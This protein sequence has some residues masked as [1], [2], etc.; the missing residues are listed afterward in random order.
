MTLVGLL[1]A[2]TG[3]AAVKQLSMS[4]TQARYAPAV[5][6]RPLWPPRTVDGEYQVTGTNPPGTNPSPDLLS[7]NP[8]GT[9]IGLLEAAGASFEGYKPASTPG[10]RT[11]LAAQ[12]LLGTLAGTNMTT[13]TMGANVTFQSNRPGTT[14]F[15]F[16]PPGTGLQTVMVFRP[17][18]RLGPSNKL[19]GNAVVDVNTGVPQPSVM[20]P[21][22]AIN[23]F[24]RGTSVRGMP[25]GAF[26][27]AIL[28]ELTTQHHLLWPV[29]HPAL[30][31]T[32]ASGSPFT[33]SISAGRNL[34]I[35]TKG[36]ATFKTRGAP[37][38]TGTPNPTTLTPTAD[39][40]VP[41]SFLW[42]PGVGFACV[43]KAD[44]ANE[45]KAGIQYFPRPGFGRFGGTG[46]QLRLRPRG[47]GPSDQGGRL[48]TRGAAQ[49]A[50]FVPQNPNFSTVVI[51]KPI[52]PSNP[53]N[54]RPQNVGLPL[55]F[56]QSSM[57]PAGVF[58]SANTLGPPLNLLLSLAPTP[59]KIS[60][61]SGGTTTAVGTPLDGR[62]W[63][64]PLT[65]GTIVISVVANAAG[66]QETQYTTGSDNRNSAG[67]GSL[68]LVGGAI[69]CCVNGDNNN[70]ERA[71]LTFT[72]E[73]AP[74]VGAVAALA[75]L[76][77]GHWIVRRRREA[78]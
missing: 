76:M 53:E 47:F 49:A 11:F 61:G 62:R 64:G 4:G 30:T 5:S 42:C 55:G 74:I 59:Y 46:G 75:A 1:S 56:Y 23:N 77:G 73:P 25:L 70:W 67:V 50:G 7:T 13:T 8:P 21:F 54:G 12:T 9:G 36:V 68:T 29:K 22:Q 17:P 65:T 24:N 16:N 72:P 35:Q 60:D 58:Y 71:K 37:I 32:G 41:V 40:L 38:T 43:D 33:S 63:G 57:A 44:P 45:R 3:S 69:T 10:G 34:Q 6:P 2:T 19:T 78:D 14:P 18:V 31:Q 51:S 28:N 27:A 52:T 26:N 48:V 20:M 66:N 15:G 39:G